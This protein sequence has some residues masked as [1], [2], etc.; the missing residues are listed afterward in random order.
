[1][2]QLFTLDRCKSSAARFDI[3]KLV[4]MNGEY[5]RRQPRDVYASEFVARV[6][7]A[8]LPAEGVD[9]AGVMD[10]MQV[11]TKFYSEIPASCAYFFTE[12]YAF[13]SEGCEKGSNPKAFPSSGGDRGEIRDAAAFDVQSA[14]RPARRD[15][16][17]ARC[18]AWGFGASVRVAV[19][20]LTEGPGSSRCWSS[21]ARQD[22]RPAAQGGAASARRQSLRGRPGT[23]AIRCV[24]HGRGRPGTAL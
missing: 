1:M 3:K 17:D 6:R 15:G 8:G 23:R 9:L 13:R 5:I 4:W 14:P 12:D 2:I 20:G 16:R 24:I 10:Q 19:S 7:A 18:G 22:L 11:R 21:S